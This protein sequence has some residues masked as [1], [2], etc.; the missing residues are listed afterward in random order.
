[1]S[2][3]TLS[4]FIGSSIVT[5]TYPI[6][7]ESLGIGTTFIFY[8]FMMLPGAWFVKKMIPE[9]KGKT[10]EEIEHHWNKQHAAQKELVEA[11]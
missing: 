8:A 9:T 3:A 5:Q 11:V 2:L 6:F 7:R 4:L 1:M 10:L